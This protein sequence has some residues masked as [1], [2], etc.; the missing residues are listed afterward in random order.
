MA[1]TDAQGAGER[2]TRF[3]RTMDRFENG[4]FTTD[5]ERLRRAGVVL[6]LPESMDDAEVTSKLWEVIERLARLGVVLEQTDHLSDR[7]LYAHLWHHSLREDVPDLD[8]DE[9][10]GV[11]HV[12]ILGGGSDDDRRLYLKYYADE[13]TRA[14]SARDWPGFDV[15]P[16]EPLPYPREDRL[17]Q[18][19]AR[20]DAE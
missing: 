10:D 15:P 7:Q 13:K 9:D 19:Y 18:L 16:R 1:K 3:E 17:Q 2:W 14:D 20:L 6:P 4:P 8:P 12:D 5:F 11:W